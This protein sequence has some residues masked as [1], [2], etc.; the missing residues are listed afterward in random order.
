M[1]SQHFYAPNAI[2]LCFFR[3]GYLWFEAEPWKLI[4]YVD[5]YYIWINDNRLKRILS[6][7]DFS[8]HCLKWWKMVLI[9]KKGISRFWLKIGIFEEQL[10]Q[11]LKGQLP[12]SQVECNSLSSYS[13]SK[14]WVFIQNHFYVY[15]K[16]D[17][18]CHY[19]LWE[20]CIEEGKMA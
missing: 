16:I 17:I 11:V 5:I 4:A 8:A 1:L 14:Y 12:V 2:F 9:L 13:I 15:Y 20:I 3:M 6:K 19:A 18:N 10:G 7:F